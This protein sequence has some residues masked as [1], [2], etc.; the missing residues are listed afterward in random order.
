MPVPKVQFGEALYT[1]EESEGRVVATIRR[2]GDVSHQSTVR[3]YTRQG[4][5]EVARDFIERPNTDASLIT[6]LPGNTRTHNPTHTNTQGA[7]TRPRGGLR[8]RRRRPPPSWRA[9][10]LLQGRRSSS[11]WCRW[12]TT[13]S[14]RRRRS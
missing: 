12:W 6:F 14:T 2:S 1:G 9:L 5:A 11:A 3:C 7:H 4:S 13:P 8:R 10:V